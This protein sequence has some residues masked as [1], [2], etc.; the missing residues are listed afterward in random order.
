MSS[1]ITFDGGRERWEERGLGGGNG[2]A[3]HVAPEERR[4]GR[5][6]VGNFESSVI[7]GPLFIVDHNL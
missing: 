3:A 5:V 4:G 7:A 2:A 6:E 1:Y